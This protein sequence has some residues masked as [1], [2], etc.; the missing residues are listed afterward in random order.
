[1]LTQN[2]IN[3][4]ISNPELGRQYINAVSN[5]YE[6]FATEFMGH[7]VEEVPPFHHAMYQALN[8]GYKY[9]AFI[10]F[11]GGAKCLHEL[12]PV[13][14]KDFTHKCIKDIS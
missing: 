2:K 11:R 12:T 1:M 5:D 3:N 14:M 9:S 6:L 4:F 13:M 10:V 7:I 8:Q